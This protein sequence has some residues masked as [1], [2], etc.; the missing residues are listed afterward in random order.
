MKDAKL[1][2]LLI[3]S[4]LFMSRG[5]SRSVLMTTSVNLQ[6][7]T[8]DSDYEL[9]CNY[10]SL[11][12]CIE[13]PD[14]S[15]PFQSFTYRILLKNPD[16]TIIFITIEHKSFNYFED[17]QLDI[18]YGVE[19]TREETLI[20]SYKNTTSLN[21]IEKLSVWRGEAWLN[22][23]ISKHQNLSICYEG[24]PRTI[25]EKVIVK[26]SGN[27]QIDFLGRYP[28]NTIKTWILRDNQSHE[29][30]GIEITVSAL[31]LDEKVG[32]TIMISPAIDEEIL[33]G[34]PTYLL[35]GYVEETK[36]FVASKDVYIIF[37]SH[38]SVRALPG[39]S[40]SWKRTGDKITPNKDVSTPLPDSWYQAI[41]ICLYQ[42]NASDFT[43]G[44]LAA[45]I[46]SQLMVAGNRYIN[47]MQLD[48]PLIR[49]KDVVFI[50]AALIL[51]GPSEKGEGL[52]LLF[53]IV[54][55]EAPKQALFTADQ[56]LDIIDMFRPS[57]NENL[58]LLVTNCPTSFDSITWVIVSLCV[59][60]IFITFFL[61]VWRWRYREF[62]NI[63]AKK[64]N[65]ERKEAEL[66]VSVWP[67]TTDNPVFEPEIPESPGVQENEYVEQNQLP[68]PAMKTSVRSF[69]DETL[70]KSSR[71]MSES[72]HAKPNLIRSLS[73]QN[74][75]TDSGLLRSQS[76]IPSRNRPVDK[77]LSRSFSE[78][79]LKNV[80]VIKNQGTES[81]FA[82]NKS[83]DLQST[84]STSYRSA[85]QDFQ[86]P[87][88]SQHSHRASQQEFQNPLK[89]N[90]D[91]S[92]T[93]NEKCDS[94][95][96]PKKSVSFRSRE[97][98][99]NPLQEE[100]EV[101]KNEKEE[102]QVRLSSVMEVSEPVCTPGLGSLPR[103]NSAERLLEDSD[104]ESHIYDDPMEIRMDDFLE[105]GNAE[106]R[107]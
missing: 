20:T 53:T 100:M 29:N 64:A 80:L 70:K 52:Y 92:M 54:Q 97:L 48:L 16:T 13:F 77:T 3:I 37:V 69:H 95:R 45:N 9:N 62:W 106:T 88:T 55:R 30:G 24:V 41:P 73:T 6:P 56:L 51:D 22:I 36:V 58:N 65:E 42:L 1:I 49:E 25:D 31:H 72:S 93:A 57:L 86:Y 90:S 101:T 4:F 26:D 78:Q 39:F 85:Q 104:K 44:N 81:S 43:E 34:S 23:R 8:G 98:P 99:L 28:S 83:F 17:Y 96:L 5:S 59:L 71:S 38:H 102:S 91:K 11:N 32:D 27:I 67:S 33:C 103:V 94:I 75:Y 63:R 47:A 87:S 66:Q 82:K 50:R 68:P 7:Q 35:S 105:V 61:F 12:S 46:K 60:P 14:I 18:G 76:S 84:P 10:T 74:V 21:K 79:S 40:F 15:S 107:L 89:T 2:V 19:P